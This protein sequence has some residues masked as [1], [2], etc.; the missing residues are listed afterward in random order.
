MGNSSILERVQKDTEGKIA[1][2]D[3]IITLIYGDKKVGKST[4]ASRFP[5]PL[6]LDCEDGLRTV[7]DTTGH[8][9]DHISVQGWQDVLDL[10]AQLEGDL[11]GYETIVVD[12]LNELWSYLVKFT[13]EKYKV[14]HTNDGTLAYGKG[15][16]IMGRAFRSWFQR[17]RRLPAGIVLTAHDKVLPFE[18]NGVAY[19]KRVPY[20]DDSKMAQAWDTI[21]P[22]INMI[23]YAHKVDT[24]DGVVHAMR[25]KGTQLI[26]AADPYG[27]LP[28][29]MPFN[30]ASLQE[31]M[32]TNNEVTTND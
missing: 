2:L 17:L 22:A 24:K 13:L 11:N 4:F 30:Y 28:E 25:T 8:R 18:H 26:E 12:G 32:E 20:V 31:A 16:A 9:P 29:L 15:N 23:L 14:E 1:G 10:T 27:N 3:E 19:D 21:K 5:K 6:F 7:Q